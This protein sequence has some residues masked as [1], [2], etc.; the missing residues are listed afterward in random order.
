MLVGYCFGLSDLVLRY[1]A[2]I[3]RTECR[4]NVGWHL[5]NED[6]MIATEFAD[7]FD[8]RCVGF[9]RMKLV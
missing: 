8:A 6:L 2:I 4:R 9:E 3:K 7:Q 5:L 1:K